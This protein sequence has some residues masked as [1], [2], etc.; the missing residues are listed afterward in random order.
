MKYMILTYG[1]QQDYD[2]LGSDRP[3]TADELAAIGE[4]LRTFTEDLAESGELVDA[5]GLSAPVLARRVQFRDG[6]AVVTDATADGHRA[7]PADARSQPVRAAVA[8]VARQA[9]AART[10]VVARAADLEVAAAARAA[11][12]RAVAAGGNKAWKRVAFACS[13]TSECLTRFRPETSLARLRPR[14]I[15]LSS[16]LN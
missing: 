3:G 13:R 12:R 4:F 5:Q 8:R 11:S 1:S 6:V 10:R 16:G 7:H 2:A 9:G 15:C 14:W